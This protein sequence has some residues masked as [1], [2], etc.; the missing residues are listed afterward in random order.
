M[1]TKCWLG[2]LKGG[3]Y[4]GYQA[5]GGRI[6]TDLRKILLVWIEFI[7]LRQDRVW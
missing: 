4:L 3:E 7:W 5:I 2:N 6:K 1:H